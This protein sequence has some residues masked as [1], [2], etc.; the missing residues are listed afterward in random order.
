MNELVKKHIWKTSDGRELSV[1]KMETTHLFNTVK[2]IWNHYCP[3]DLQIRPFKRWRINLPHD[4]LA[5]SVRAM[6]VELS[7]RDDVTE[8]MI[9]EISLMRLNRKRLEDRNKLL[10]GVK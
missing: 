4:Y 1:D 9:Y 2:M 10:I 8:E 5:E 3:E 7:L 6:L